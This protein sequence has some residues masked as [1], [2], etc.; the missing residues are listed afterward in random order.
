MIIIC[1]ITGVCFIT[2][3]YLQGEYAEEMVRMRK[4]QFDESVKRSLDQASRDLERSETVN[5]LQAVMANYPVEYDS[6]GSVSHVA[7]SVMDSP[8]AMGLLPGDSVEA[9]PNF[10]VHPVSSSAVHQPLSLQVAPRPTILSSAQHFQ[11][12]V[13]DAYLYQRGVLD[14][15]V[16]AVLYNA[17]EKSF[18]D[19]IDPRFLDGCMRTSLERNGVTLPFHFTICTSDGREVYRC[20]DYDE[21]GMDHVYTQTLFRNDPSQKMGV[22]RVHFP[23]LSH[24]VMG[25]VRTMIPAFGF[26]VLLF[27]VFILTIWLTIRQKKVSEMKNDFINNMTH[28]FKTPIS[29][30]SLAAQMLADKSIT[31]S[32]SMYEN[33]GNIISTETRR[34]RFQVEKVLQMSL[35]DRNNIALKYVELNADELIDSVVNTFSL[36]V[37]QNGG[38]IETHL[39]SRNPLVMVDEMHFTNVIFNLMDNAVKYKRD[40]VDLKLVVRTWN[41]GEKLCISIQDN[42]IGIRKEDLRRIFEKFYRVHTGNQHNVK[43]FGL[44]LAYV[45]KMIDLHHGTIKV[46]SELGQGTKFILVLPSIKMD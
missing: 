27:G 9:K 21:E 11:K 22:V 37:R 32:P 25:A 35:F 16:Y 17:S 10:K 8:M 41:Q 13:R 34:L 14:E 15:V 42:G 4:D 20:P 29:S 44:G 40:D 43:G 33:L 38:E 23:G 24:Y 30:I 45:K 1:V 6:L 7:P 19:R 5:Y 28:E 3:L 31:K 2:L 26:T 12:A 46:E 18:E 36:K 39:E